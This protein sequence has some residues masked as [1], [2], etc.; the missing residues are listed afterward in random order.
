M[1][2]H[3]RGKGITLDKILGASEGKDTR[4]CKIICTMGPSC[5]D[6]E[7]LV[8]M[9][10]A[11]M[12]VARLN[13][14]HGDHE[15]HGRTVANIRAAI[16]ERPGCN[17]AIMLDTKGPEIRTGKLKG[18][19]NV[20]LKEGQT[21]T[22]VVDYEFE[23]DNT[24]I[25]CSYA[26]LP[27][28]VKVGSTILVA[29]GNLVLTVTELLEGGVV[30]RV[31]NDFVL[32]EK[33]NMNLP[34][35]IV[36]LPTITEKD[37]HD[38]VG[39]GLRYNVDMIAA[40]FLRK[41]SDVA[42]I[43][44]VLGDAGEHIKVIAK[45]ENQEGL[46]NYDSIVQAA[47][48]IMV[49]R[50]DL[51]MELPPEKVFL[52]QKMMIRKANLYGVPVITATQMLESMIKN[53]RPTRAECTDVA[54]AVIDG[55]DCVML[56]GET[57]NGMFPIRAVDMMARVCIEAEAVT[58]YEQLFRAIRGSTLDETPG[59]MSITESIA[60][61]AVKTSIDLNAKL[62]IVCTETGNSARMLAKYRPQARILVLT[63]TQETARYCS[64]LFRGVVKVVCMGS[65]VGTDGILMRAMDLARDWEWIESGDSV[66]A[67]HGQFEG[68]PG[69][70]NM[71]KVLTA[72]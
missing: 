27:T 11:G 36:D 68:R 42:F 40:S 7:M 51:G 57:A 5:W 21:L 9:I 45:I 55:T 34:G 18:G 58:N 26:S 16:A 54:N 53:P 66:L 1:S 32:G 35:V 3:L 52:A 33:K 17:V 38:I 64:G 69:H 4:K 28:S 14:S 24:T 48:G 67:L 72:P 19:A 50:G 25:A 59:P 30:T 22:I 31:M 39:F 70:T 6:K 43:K 41:A 23:G 29:D 61:S 15:T 49:A 65:M 2:I 20:E 56:S 47:D 13:F 63:A 60:S 10:D 12:N 46:E 37:R 71:V 62:I 44:E 8:Q